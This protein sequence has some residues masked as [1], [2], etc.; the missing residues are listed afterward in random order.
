MLH[1]NSNNSIKKDLKII[2]NK[3]SVIQKD[4]GLSKQGKVHV[5]VELIQNL[6]LSPNT[7]E[8]LNEIMLKSNITFT[9]FTDFANKNG[10][11][12]WSCNALKEL[13]EE[14]NS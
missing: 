3:V 7:R 14:F 4:D 13:I 8:F 9:D 11:E 1:S 5:F 6:E 2:C 12:N 10:L